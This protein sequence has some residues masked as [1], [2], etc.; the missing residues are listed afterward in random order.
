LFN[1]A[2]TDVSRLR[3]DIPQD[4]Q[5]LQELILEQRRGFLNWLDDAEADKSPRSLDV[6]LR[7]ASYFRD[8]IVWLPQEL[9]K[10]VQKA[11]NFIRRA[12]GQPL[13]EGPGLEVTAK[14]EEPSH[15]AESIYNTART[16][17]QIRLPAIT[18]SWNRNMGRPKPLS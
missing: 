2:L 11:Y 18:A 13:D 14:N 8:A 10:A 5:E 7:D 17:T 1:K 12:Q 6:K 3:S 9:S 4:I 16:I 15:A